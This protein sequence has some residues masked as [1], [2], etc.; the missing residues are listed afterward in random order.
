MKPLS[1]AERRKL[2]HWDPVKELYDWADEV[3]GLEACNCWTNGLEWNAPRATGFMH[4]STFNRGCDM[5]LLLERMGA[6][7]IPK[8]RGPVRRIMDLGT[9]AHDLMNFYQG[10]RAYVNG[11][12]YEHDVPAMVEGL[13]V[14]G[15]ADG[16]TIGWPLD[17]PILWEYKTINKRGAAGLKHPSKSYIIQ[18]NVYMKALGIPAV[19]FV[20]INKDDSS[21]YHFVV[22]YSESMWTMIERKA[23]Y[24]N[25]I[26]DALVEDAQRKVSNSCFSCPYYEECEPPIRKR[27]FVTAPVL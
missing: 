6:H 3:Q 1:E 5:M 12:K 15:S 9:A 7:P 17:R 8:M 13:F 26:A 24:I 27:R 16:L 23:R 11:Y 2:A 4:A 21:F 10:T 25:K 14:G 18:V 22:E 20:Y 19:V